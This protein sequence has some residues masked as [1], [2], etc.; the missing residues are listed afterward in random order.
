MRVVLISTYDLGHQPFGLASPAAFLRSEGHEVTTADLS[1]ECF[2]EEAV[3]AADWIAFHL[4]MHTAT[5]LAIPRIRT[6]R[7]LNLPARICCYGLYAAA[8]QEMLGSLGVTH[9]IGGEFEKA[10]ADLI[11][12]RPGEGGV[13][14][15][16]VSGMVFDRLQFH[17][18]DRCGLPLL[19]EYAAVVSGGERKVAGYTEASRGCKHLC[20]HCPV[21]PVYE[22]RFRVVQREVVL[23]D[24]RQQIEAGAQHITFGDP[25]FLNGPGHA[26]AIVE[27]FHEEFPAVTYDVTIKIEHLLRHRDLLTVLKR[28]GC[29]FITSAVESLDDRVLELL[30]KG[31]TRADFLEA[32]ELTRAHGLTLSPTFLPFTPWTSREDYLD[33]LR[34]IRD[35]GLVENVA[36]IQLAIRLLIPAGSKLLELPDLVAG[37]FDAA[38][39]SYRWDHP[40]PE[41][42]TLCADLQKIAGGC[43]S[44]T[45][46]FG[47]IWER[48][49]GVK[50]E[51]ANESPAIPRMTENWYCCAEPLETQFVPV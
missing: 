11:G 17:V 15:G 33:L 47:R 38:A 29:L 10:L 41:M 32:I 12:G 7:A 3:R 1:R 20:R 18:P 35:L 22:G 24:A 6:A 42:D 44:R 30:A 31:H 8:N 36:P 51:L 34:T 46:I 23:A 25:D 43:G 26:R 48:A 19:R 45:E 13:V 5:R 28:T 39:L 9:V 14:S 37:P 21:V 4:P 49:F 40:D 50:A 16:V 2:P 27:A